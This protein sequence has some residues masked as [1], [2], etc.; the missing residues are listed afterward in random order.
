MTA[1]EVK[2]YLSHLTSWEENEEENILS[3]CKASLNE[4]TS[5]LKADADRADARIASA[6]A[7]NAYYKLSLK[8]SF[9]SSQ[10]EFTSFK[11]GDVSITQGNSQNRSE[12]I[13][14]KAE[15]LYHEALRSIIPLCQD[16]GF[17][18]ENVKIKVIP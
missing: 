12:K 15:K 2:D 4:I 13:L 6:A 1:W 9:S 3:L 8:R 17:A 16:N 14:D 11:A 7:A 18:F 5:M 10:E